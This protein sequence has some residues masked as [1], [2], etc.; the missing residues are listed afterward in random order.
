MGAVSVG[1]LVTT[2]S[3]AASDALA[4]RPSYGRHR[5][6]RRGGC[7][8]RRATSGRT[9]PRAAGTHHLRERQRGHAVTDGPS[10]E[11]VPRVVHAPMRDSSGPEC[12]R[13]L[14]MPEL[15]AVDVAA[16]RSGEEDRRIDPRRHSLERVEHALPERNRPHRSRRLATRLH[17]PAGEAAPHM[18]RLRVPIHIGTV[19][20]EQ[21]LR[22]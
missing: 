3:R 15:L 11:R 1:A 9:C 19:K 12:R 21:L 22:A 6:T 20:P 8:R 18:Q 7:P 16:A 4:A 14:A 10:R 13:P 17:D 2:I 5:R